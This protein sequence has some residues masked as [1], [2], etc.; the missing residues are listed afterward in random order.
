MEM[1]RGNVVSLLMFTTGGR[2]EGGISCLRPR[3]GL[4]FL[5]RICTEDLVEEEYYGKGGRWRWIRSGPCFR[6]K[7]MAM[8]R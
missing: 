2:R 6:A 8:E 7:L 1:R 5:R 3:L 4:Q